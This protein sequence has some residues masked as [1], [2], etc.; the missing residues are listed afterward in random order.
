[1]EVVVLEISKHAWKWYSEELHRERAYG[2]LVSENLCR[3]TTGQD[4]SI[5]FAVR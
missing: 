5:S 2:S 4:E 3:N 1:M